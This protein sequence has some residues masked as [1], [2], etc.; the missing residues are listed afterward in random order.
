VDPF[1]LQ[2]SA[3]SQNTSFWGLTAS[4]WRGVANGVVGGVTGT[5]RLVAGLATHPVDTVS[6]VGSDLSMRA[7]TMYEVVRHPIQAKEAIT[8]AIMELGPNRAMEILGDAGGNVIAVKGM[9]QV[10]GLARTGIASRF[11]GAGKVPAAAAA[12]QEWL[13]PGWKMIRSRA[14]EPIFISQM[15]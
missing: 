10:A 2:D 7:Q 12:I 9:S 1:G 4:Y 13:G 15:G 8:D 11:A 3:G 6:A 5:G 14:G